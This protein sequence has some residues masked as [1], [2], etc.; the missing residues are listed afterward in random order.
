MSQPIRAGLT[1]TPCVR[2]ALESGVKSDGK[3]PLDHS[4]PV[5]LSEAVLIAGRGTPRLHKP[6]DLNPTQ[7]CLP[8]FIRHTV[9]TMELIRLL[10]DKVGGGQ[11]TRAKTD[12]MV[13]HSKSVTVV[14]PWYHSQTQPPRA[15]R[16][17]RIIGPIRERGGSGVFSSHIRNVA[18]KGDELSPLNLVEIK[19]IPGVGLI[20]ILDR[21]FKG[22][23]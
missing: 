13:I 6:L 12:A 15:G 21:D 20:P 1:Q 22:P 16:N 8:V 9:M 3:D 5:G 23:W 11:R 19:D 2:P 10:R 17:Q 14:C 4:G 18:W 7:H